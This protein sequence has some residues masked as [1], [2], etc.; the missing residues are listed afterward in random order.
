MS[1]QFRCYYDDGT[2]VTSDECPHES[3]NG[4]PLINT[5]YQII[6]DVLAKPSYF[7]LFIILGLVVFTSD[8]FKK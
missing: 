2:I 4:A 5:E 7:W 8:S 3:P 1:D 6:E